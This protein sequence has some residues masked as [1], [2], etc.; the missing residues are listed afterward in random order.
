MERHTTLSL[1]LSVS[2]RGD[3]RLEFR[4]VA[5]VVQGHRER[6]RERK[7]EISGN[8]PIRPTE[9]NE[10][11]GRDWNSKSAL[12]PPRFAENEIVSRGNRRPRVL[13]VARPSDVSAGT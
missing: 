7:R 9:M 11:H 4:H 1:S 3:D 5:P 8:L 10:V 6:E 13:R 2:S 12:R